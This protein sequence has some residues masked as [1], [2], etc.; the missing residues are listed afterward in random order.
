VGVANPVLLKQL[1]FMKI[2]PSQFSLGRHSFS[3]VPYWNPD[4]V[5]IE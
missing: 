2:K 4:M 1:I 5:I 3:D